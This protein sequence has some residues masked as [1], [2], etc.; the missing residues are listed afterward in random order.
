M[1]QSKYTR[2]NIAPALAGHA[3]PSEHLGFLN[4]FLL[5]DSIPGHDRGDVP[6]RVVFALFPRGEQL[7]SARGSADLVGG[8]LTTLWIFRPVSFAEDSAWLETPLSVT[9]METSILLENSGICCVAVFPCHGAARSMLFFPPPTVYT[10]SLQPKT[11][12]RGL[13]QSGSSGPSVTRPG[14]RQEALGVMGPLQSP[15]GSPLSH[16][17][18]RPRMGSAFCCV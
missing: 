14:N 15:P 11:A 13:L 10:A 9:R 12:H 6:A 3:Q 18:A 17:Q 7:D 2:G 16:R 4:S 5:A 1:A 8:H